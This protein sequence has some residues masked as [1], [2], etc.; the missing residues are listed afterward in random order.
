MSN[1]RRLLHPLIY[2]KFER[3]E[4]GA[5]HSTNNGFVTSARR[6]ERRHCGRHSAVLP[7]FVVC[8]AGSSITC[9][10]DADVS[11]SHGGN[12]S[13][14]S[15]RIHQLPKEDDPDWR[16]PHWIKAEEYTHFPQGYCWNCKQ[17]GLRS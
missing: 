14:H 12:R 4:T 11:Q 10:R 6:A 13:H 3:A 17:R 16:S 8:V 7:E 2:I 5:N 1:R 15:L 9:V